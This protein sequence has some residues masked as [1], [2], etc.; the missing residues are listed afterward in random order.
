ISMTSLILAYFSPLSF[1]ASISMEI[2]LSHMFVFRVLEKL[3]LTHITGNEF[4][5][6]VIVSFATVIG[7]I[8]IAFI[9]KRIIEVIMI[10]SRERRWRKSDESING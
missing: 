1:I 8:V 4:I 2:Y 9:L 7:A 6:Y 5:N 3:K 10:Q